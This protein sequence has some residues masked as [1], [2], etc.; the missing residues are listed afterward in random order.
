VI[1]KTK[2][3]STSSR[4]LCGKSGIFE[5]AY[6][7]PPVACR[8]GFE[9]AALMAVACSGVETGGKEQL[10]WHIPLSF[11]VPYS[12]KPHRMFRIANLQRLPERP[13]ADLT[14]SIFCLALKT[15]N[16]ARGISQQRLRASLYG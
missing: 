10:A 15:K 4:S 11:C 7:G 1:F 5:N 13:L 3:A 12:C 2:D 8:D 9:L 14:A 6:H 16:L